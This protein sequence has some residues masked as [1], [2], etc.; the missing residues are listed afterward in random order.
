MWHEFQPPQVIQN[1]T[2]ILADM[3]GGGIDTGSLVL[4]P[5]ISG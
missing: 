4:Q 5:L 3:L 2:Q 1:Q